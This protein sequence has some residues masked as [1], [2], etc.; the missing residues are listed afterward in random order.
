MLQGATRNTSVGGG[1]G[2]LED[3]VYHLPQEETSV[4]AAGGEEE[5]VIAGEG[6][7]PH[8]SSQVAVTPTRSQRREHGER[9]E[10]HLTL[11]LPHSQQVSLLR[12]LHARGRALSF[13]LS[14]PLRPC[15]RQARH[16]LPLHL[17]EHLRP[18]CQLQPAPCSHLPH[19]RRRVFA[20]A[21]SVSPARG[22]V[23]PHHGCAMRR[24]PADIL[25]AKEKRSRG[26][27]GASERRADGKKGE[28]PVEPAGEESRVIEEEAE[29]REA[30]ALSPP[31]SLLPPPSCRSLALE[32]E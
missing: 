11:L 29:R 6:K 13:L 10:R 27:G 7:S 5:R 28:T 32:G 18:P 26:G 3:V 23:D 20:A 19:L 14:Q 16:R 8:S 24:T 12:S 25:R 31:S 30:A 22:H 15:A 9:E 17:L 21:L 4:A 1:G 2:G